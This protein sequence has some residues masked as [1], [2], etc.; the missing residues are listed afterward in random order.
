[1]KERISLLL[2]R[3]LVRLSMLEQQV[4]KMTKGRLVDYLTENSV[5]E[6]LW[7]NLV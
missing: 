1:M 2:A 5:D 3:D 4:M 6:G 7:N